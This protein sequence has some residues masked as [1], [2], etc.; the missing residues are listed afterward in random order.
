MHND[1][2]PEEWLI[3]RDW[4]PAD[5]EASA[6]K[7]GFIRRSTGRVNAETWLKLILMH[8]AGGLSLDQTMLRASELGWANLS[9]VALFKRLRVAQEWLSQ[10]CSSLL[11]FQ[12]ARLGEKHPWPKE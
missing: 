6:Q 5:L 8:V 7:C 9:A 11:A 2:L 1:A 12:R 3:L 4:L 10:L